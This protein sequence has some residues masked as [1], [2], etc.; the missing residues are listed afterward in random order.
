[1]SETIKHIHLHIDLFLDN[2]SYSFC[3]LLFVIISEQNRTH[4]KLIDFEWGWVLFVY[5]HAK[6]VN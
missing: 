3:F 2:S 6:Y 5:S 4:R 1:M